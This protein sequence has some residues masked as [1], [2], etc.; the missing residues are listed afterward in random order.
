MKL[1]FFGAIM[2][3]TVLVLVTLLIPMALFL[4]STAYSQTV[5]ELEKN[6]FAVAGR[7][8]AMLWSP[9]AANTAYVDSIIRAYSNDSGARVVVTDANG[10][11]LVTTDADGGAVGTSFAGRPEVATALSG[12]LATG[13][14]YSNSI[15]GQLLYVAVPV[16]NGDQTVGAVR[17]TF[18]ATVVQSRLDQQISLLWIVGVSAMALAAIVA[19]ILSTSVTR[20]IRNLQRTAE[21]IT[22]GD[23]TSRS[24][25]RKGPPEIRALARAYNR[26]SDRLNEMLATQQRFA[27]DASHQLR[28]P[29]TALRLRIETAHE[30]LQSDPE[31][32]AARL[33]AAEHEAERLNDI[34]EALL[35]L[36]RGELDSGNTEPVDVAAAAQ[37]MCEVWSPL[38]EE[39]G[40]TVE[41]L[42][43]DSV[44]AR[45]LPGAIEQVVGNLVDNAIRASKPSTTVTIQVTRE[46]SEAVLKVL[47]EGR[48]MTT[49]ELAQAFDRFWRSDTSSSGTG[50]G[51]AIVRKL[52]EASGGT[53]GLMQRIPT[54]IV[55]I[56]RLPLVD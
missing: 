26:M 35:L 4:R 19:L 43:V 36:S 25:E 23:L 15:G 2:G 50:I 18:P 14:R 53:V 5:T 37:A 6:A 32:A 40:V 39:S 49:D 28:S 9:S 55:A 16:L 20:P 45:A 54:G 12:Q 48:G 8:T 46:G 21:A 51:L 3:V 27:A 52:V 29:L 11:A 7:S 42:G 1:R 10:I 41:Y 22:E 44:I 56:V 34:V 33:E 13:Q 31:R 47:D 38:A 30:L 24:D 17:I